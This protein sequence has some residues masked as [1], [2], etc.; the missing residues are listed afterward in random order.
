MTEETPI[1]PPTPRKVAFLIDGEVVEVLNT[2]DRLAALFL[3]EPLVLD[4]TDR[5]DVM[6]ATGNVIGMHYDKDR[7]L[8]YIPVIES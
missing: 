7:D 3:S 4:V 1:N 6:Q 8:F 5:F 2:D